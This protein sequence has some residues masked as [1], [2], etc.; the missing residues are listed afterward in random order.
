MENKCYARSLI[1]SND[2]EFIDG[3]QKYL[4]P[5]L[6]YHHT[7]G[8]QCL[9]CCFHRLIG[10]N[11]D[12]RIIIEHFA[13]TY[14]SFICNHKN[15]SPTYLEKKEKTKE[16]II[17]SVKKLLTIRMIWSFQNYESILSTLQKTHKIFLPSY[18]QFLFLPWKS[19]FDF[20]YFVLT[21]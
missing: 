16:L 2:H 19:C 1:G 17:I 14:Q 11:C 20:F 15:I 18:L 10:E 21:I 8:K 6:K 3:N 9:F 5:S 12:L 4:P 7:H 13:F